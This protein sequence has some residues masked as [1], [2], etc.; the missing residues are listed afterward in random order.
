MENWEWRIENYFPFCHFSIKN[1]SFWATIGSRRIFALSTPLCRPSVRR[2]FDFV[3]SALRSGWHT[4]WEIYLSIS[5]PKDFKNPS[6][7]AR[8]EILPRVKVESR[9]CTLC[10]SKLS[11]RTIVAKGP[12]GYNEKTQNNRL[13]IHRE[14]LA[15]AKVEDR[16]CI[17]YTTRSS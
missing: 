6:I 3:R 8:W 5:S 12:A 15:Q 9:R 2:S 14:I 17:G 4:V 1:A 11:K 10:T 13:P 7:V 16:S